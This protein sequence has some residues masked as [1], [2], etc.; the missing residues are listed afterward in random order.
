MGSGLHVL[1][2]MSLIRPSRNPVE[3][4]SSFN[5][6]G[7]QNGW[8]SKFEIFFRTATLLKHF[9]CRLVQLWESPMQTDL[10][11]TRCP[12]GK[13]WDHVV[14]QHSVPGHRPGTPMQSDPS[15]SPAGQACEG[16][17]VAI[18]YLPIRVKNSYSQFTLFFTPTCILEAS[19][20]MIV[21][22]SC[23]VPC[24]RGILLVASRVTLGRVRCES[25]CA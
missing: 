20:I 12:A 11:A 7:R 4:S 16:E 13:R 22:A 2:P 1:W 24:S 18:S 10:K 14:T 23:I 15:W 19:Q 25:T 17:T 8:Y 21:R 3:F 9:G 5:N 6:R